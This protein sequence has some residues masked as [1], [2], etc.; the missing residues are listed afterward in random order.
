[1]VNTSTKEIKQLDN[2]YHLIM[3]ETKSTSLNL[4]DLLNIGGSYDLLS[5]RNV[6]LN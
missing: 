2:F 5:N 1:M 3:L 4:T 6:I